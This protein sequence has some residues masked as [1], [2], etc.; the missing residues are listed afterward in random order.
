MA[1]VR[2]L[3][4]CQNGQELV[5]FALLAPVMLL[6]F[7]GVVEAGRA[8]A[9]E[10]RLSVLTREAA[11]VA[12]RGSSLTEALD[13]A[14]TN[15]SDMDLAARG[16][17]IASRIVVVDSVPV[18]QAQQTS[19]GYEERSLLGLPDSIVGALNALELDEGQSLYAVEL[20]Y[21]QPAFTPLPAM[22]GG[23]VSTL[24][25]RAIF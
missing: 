5:E 13:V 22:V 2:R 18:I 23:W 7:V 16:G 10:H 8:I 14:M 20:F 4:A 25:E 3:L 9:A 11:N 12:S 17:G 15:G 24:Y 19:P 21:D 6:L 1:C